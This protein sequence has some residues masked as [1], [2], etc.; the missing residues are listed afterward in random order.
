[1]SR[2][3]PFYLII[4]PK[5]AKKK[6]LRRKR[7]REYIR[8]QLPSQMYDAINN[9]EDTVKLAKK[10]C[11]DQNI[12]VAAGGDGTVADVIQGIIEA[13]RGMDVLFGIIPLGSGNAFRKSLDIPLNMKKAVKI[14]SERKTRAIDLID[15]EGKAAG[16][17]SVGVIAQL[18]QEKLKHNIPGLLGHLLTV[19]LVLSLSKKEQEIELIDGIEDDG[20]HFDKKILILNL[21]DCVVGKTNYFGYNWKIAPRAKLD[22]GLLDITF[23]EISALKYLLLLPLIYFG[24]YQKKLRHFKAKKMIIKGKELHIQY[25]GEYFGVKDRVEVKV[26]PRALNIICPENKK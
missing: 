23:F 1:M 16:F 22:D 25:N 14:L 21:L 7:L 18:T 4:N 12:I 11:L 26:L 24:L 17:A 8:K 10:I 2:S 20:K 6:W 3:D 5:A 15:V 9:K 19:R 13:R